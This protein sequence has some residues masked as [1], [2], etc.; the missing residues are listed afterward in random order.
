MTACVYCLGTGELRDEQVLVRGDDFYVCAPLGQVVEG[1]VAIA[2]Y[3]CIGCL[4]SLP[5]DWIDELTRLKHLVAE[6]YA[7]AY[8]VSR[9]TFYEQGRAGGGVGNEALTGFPLHAHL[10][11][12]PIALDM[13]AMLVGHFM[14][15]QVAGLHEL[16]AVAANDPY[17]YVESGGEEW[18][19]LPRTHDE[20]AEL[21][22]LRIKPE[23]AAFI[24]RPERGHW[25]AY[26]GDHEVK[27][28]IDRFSA[29][30]TG[31]MA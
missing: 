8:G 9:P 27:R 22:T 4:A 3:R 7:D 16:S 20:R 1:Y 15:H 29:F 28:V 11:G 17:I 5:G 23:L 25:R 26:P 31:T 13:H 6:F 19:Y 10:C 18:V 2:P 14:R 21:A 24:G 12:V 30:H